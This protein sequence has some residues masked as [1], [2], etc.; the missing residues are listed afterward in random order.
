ML[1]MY[2]YMSNARDVYET[3]SLPVYTNLLCSQGVNQHGHCLHSRHT[4]N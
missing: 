2:E 1:I 3:D 4:P